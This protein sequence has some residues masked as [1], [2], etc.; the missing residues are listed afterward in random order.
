LLSGCL[1]ENFVPATAGF[2]A[3]DADLALT[4]LRSRLPASGIRHVLM[5]YFGFG[6]NYTSL[7]MQHVA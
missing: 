6:G 1:G 7:V 4:P 2:A 3:M 5:N